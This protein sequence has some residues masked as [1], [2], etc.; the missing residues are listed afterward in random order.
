MADASEGYCTLA[1]EAADQ[2]AE[3][4]WPEDGDKQAVPWEEAWPEEPEEEAWPEE[5]DEEAW[6]EE[7]DEEAWPEEPEEAVDE[8]AWQGDAW[9]ETYSGVPT[10]TSSPQPTDEVNDVWPQPDASKL[11][12]TKLREFWDKYKV[13][14]APWMHAWLLVG[15]SCCM[16][17]CLRM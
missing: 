10:P 1:E 9:E 12:S 17:A 3:E 11:P 15:V 2:A 4:L 6:P 5:P 13:P 14:P 8:D 7:P 16:C